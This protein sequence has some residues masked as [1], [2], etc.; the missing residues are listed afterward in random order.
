MCTKE[1]LRLSTVIYALCLWSIKSHVE[2][3]N[4]VEKIISKGATTFRT[5]TK[6]QRTAECH[7]TEQQT[8]SRMTLSKSASTAE[9]YINNYTPLN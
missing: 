1:L 4:V 5:M 8:F 7:S 6:E 2:D 9:Q 3:V